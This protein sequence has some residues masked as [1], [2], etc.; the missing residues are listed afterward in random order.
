MVWRIIYNLLPVHWSGIVDFLAY[1]STIFTQ[2]AHFGDFFSP[3]YIFTFNTYY[4]TAR[5]FLKLL[6]I[7]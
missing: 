4:S 3:T 6:S 5:I 7:L 2:H 1:I